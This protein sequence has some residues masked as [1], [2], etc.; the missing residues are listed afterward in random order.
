MSSSPD[1]LKQQLAELRKSL[2]KR[3]SPLDKARRALDAL[4]AGDALS[5]VA[6]LGEHLPALRGVDL[7]ALE[8]GAAHAEAVRGVEALH[9]RL[10]GVARMS[11]LAA[12][13]S[14]AS[15]EG[16]SIDLVSERPLVLALAPLE[17]RLDI[18]LGSCQ[19]LYAREVVIECPS[20]A[21]AILAA[22]RG[23]MK[24][25]RDAALPS[26]AF[27]DRA[28][29]AYGMI[30]AARGL[31]WGDRVDLVDLLAPLALLAHGVDR[32][33]SGELA[34]AAELP[35]YMLAYQLSRLRRDGLMTRDGRRLELGVATGGSARDKRGVLYLPTSASDGQYHVSLRFQ[36]RSG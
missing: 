29:Q 20:E 33:R 11:L 7:T 15:E 4:C 26:E 2:K 24:Q 34:K 10:A 21:R 35:R 27:F 23:A 36:E 9:Q 31:P 32:W 18:G 19:L 30:L 25:M 16:V 1:P 12:L 14:A 17:I 28:L 13:R 3:L 6:V 5:Q 8:L 22:R